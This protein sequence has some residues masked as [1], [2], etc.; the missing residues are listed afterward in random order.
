[1]S[2]RT[3]FIEYKPM[4]RNGGEKVCFDKL[5]AAAGMP[6]AHHIW[7]KNTRVFGLRF[8]IRLAKIN[9]AQNFFDEAL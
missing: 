3:R 7:S 6:K 2:R 5:L 9:S 8:A 1:M 4:L